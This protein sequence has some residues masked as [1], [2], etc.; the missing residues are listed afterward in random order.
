MIMGDTSTTPTRAASAPA[1]RSRPGARPLRNVAATVARLCCCSWRRG[2]S[3]PGRSAPGRQRRR[4][5]E[6][7][8]ARTV[9]YGE[10]VAT[11]AWRLGRGLKVTGAGFAL[12]VEGGASRKTRPTTRSSAHRCRASTSPK[13]VRHVPVRRRRARARH[14]ARPCRPP[15]GVGA[16]FV[17]VDD[18][19]AKRVAGFVQTVVKGDFVGVV[20]ES[21]WA[22][23][24]GREAAEG[25]VERTGRRFPS[26]RT[27]H[28]HASG[29]A[30][31]HA[32]NPRSAAM[33][34]AAMRARPGESKRATSTRSTRTRRWARDA[35]WRTC[36]RTASRPSGGARR[37]RTPCSEATPNCSASRR[38]GARRLDG[39]LRIVRA[40]R[41]RR[42]A[43]RRDDAVAGGRQAGARAVD[44]RRHDGLGTKGP[45][46]RLRIDGGLDAAGNVTGIQFTS[47]AFSGGEINSFP[48][49]GQLPRRAADGIAQHV[50][51]R[52]IRRMGRRGAARTRSPT[53][54][55]PRTSFPGFH[56]DASPLRARICAIPTDRPRRL[57]SSR[58]WTNSRLPPASD[59][60]EFRLKHLD[61]PRAKAVLAAAA[62]KYGW[63]PR[64]SPS[65]RR[66]DVVTGRGSRWAPA[67][68]PTSATSRRWK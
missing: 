29:D 10:L 32:R 55:A 60:I 18:C 21:E 58:S 40:A 4:Q 48:T 17:S 16:K 27:L 42:C 19:A 62:E 35:R 3:T 31:S 54:S 64:P 23:R 7:A 34:A 8:P 37:S 13:D 45:G 50:G 15:A 56:D 25:H 6:D 5:R 59:P 11:P 47:R 52:R 66:G 46:V 1:T 39:R 30:E 28:A 2:G 36:R 26:R 38:K 43:R 63:D 24:Q 53:C 67:T 33:R 44:A 68:A 49:R 57:R 41:V 14:A 20:A 51:L 65:V 22:R 61:E 9:S 12:N